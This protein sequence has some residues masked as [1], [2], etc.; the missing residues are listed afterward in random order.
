MN[1]TL[2][3]HANA[4]LQQ[5]GIPRALLDG[6]LSYGREVHDHHG[7][8]VVYFDRKARQ[9][10]R[11]VCGTR[12]FIKIESKLDTYAVVGADGAVITVGKRTKRINR[13]SV[14][15]QRFHIRTS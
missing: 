4:R 7:S 12:E 15:S 6:L 10:L 2:T 11:D 5:R 9:L 14:V 1:A 13:N 8:A 3:H